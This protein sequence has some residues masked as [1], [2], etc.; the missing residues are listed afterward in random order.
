MTVRQVPKVELH[1]HIEGA[2]P[3]ALVRRLAAEKGL[4]LDWLFDEEGGYAWS[5]FNSFIKAYDGAASVFQTRG[6]YA[7]LAEA[8]LAASAAEGVIYTEVFVSPDHARRTGIPYAEYIGGI[9]EGMRKA[10]ARHGIIGRI[11]PLIERHFGPETAI[12][13]ARTAVANLIP[14][15]VG[16]GMAGDERMWSP[17]D[18][19]PAFAIAHE[20]G[21]P[22]TCHAGELCDWTMVRDTLDA[23]PV[24]RIGHGVRAIENEDLVRRLADSGIVL[25]CCPVSNV[26]LGVFPGFSAHPFVRLRDAGV[27]VTLNSDDPPFFHTSMVRE[28]EIAAEAF[29]LSETELLAI[30]ATAIEAAFCDEATKA[31]LRTRALVPA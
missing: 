19:A 25:E 3:P 6:D 12:L 7:D 22:L 30:T 10:E 13:A 18:F 14:E 20:A 26:A 31:L 16:F 27:K 17:R 21:L 4:G 24:R 15:V 11:I 28:Y 23:I 5:D 1:C 8:Y 2:A 29:G 9:A